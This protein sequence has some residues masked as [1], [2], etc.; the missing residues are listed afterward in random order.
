[1]DLQ[2]RE[3]RTG[4]KRRKATLPI[5]EKLQDEAR[6]LRSWLDN[7]L[8][9]GAITPSSPALARA[10]AAAVQPERPGLVI[11]LGPGTG[12]VTEALLARGVAEDRLVLIEFDTDFCD[13]LRRRFPR[14]LVVQGDAYALAHALGKAFHRKPLPPVAAIVSSLPLL[15]RPEAVRLSLLEEAFLLLGPGAPFVQFT[16]GLVSPVPRQRGGFSAE[17]SPPIWLNLPPARVWVY[18]ADPGALGRGEQDLIDRLKDQAD[19]LREEWRE[20]A[21]KVRCD[22][23][24]KTDRVRHGFKDRTDKVRTELRGKAG[25]VAAGPHLKPT[26]DLLRKISARI[27]QSKH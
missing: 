27:D 14:A 15:M 18:R 2:R 16:Y 17:V 20:R 10:M 23:R 25:K 3:Q 22:M 7:P 6:F 11:E 13:L 9:T 4:S 12:P 21:E 8:S 1:V 26:M 19:R 24:E 5:G